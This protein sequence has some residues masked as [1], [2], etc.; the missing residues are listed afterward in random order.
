MI[1]ASPHRL[2]ILSRHAPAY[3]RLV[4]QAGLPRLTLFTATDAS[5]PGPAASCDIVLGEP[6]L[7][8][9]VLA[10]LEAVHWVQ[11]TWAGVE[12]LLG[13]S[14]PRN[15][16]LTNARG[17]F[18]GLMAEYVFGYLLAHERR[19][20][21]RYAAQ[22]AGRWDPAPPGTL[23]GRLMGL[24]GVGSIGA[25]LARTAK[26]FGLRVRG[27]T[28][29][30]EHCA[31][32]DEYFHGDAREAFAADLDYLV[33]VLP[34]T[35]HT[36][37]LVDGALLSALPPRAVFVNPGRGSVVDEQALADALRTGRL[38]RAVLDVFNEEP[39][40]PDHVFW[41]TPNLVITSHTAAIS[42]PEDIAPIFIRNYRRL[43]AG[44][45]LEYRVDFE[46]EY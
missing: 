30:S 26:H 25:A 21:E 36:R 35:G 37:G 10:R 22:R 38:A 6:S 29:A 14:L 32:V 42:A 16:V 15:Y 9:P 31:D 34:N 11:S 23:R 27:Y 19:I 4:E 20:L 33:A 7:I 39:L 46:A 43:L 5:D 3:Q 18:G 12:P 8:A 17:V 2:L 24:L 41:R 1:D 44:E 28:R 13:P 45:P 40:P